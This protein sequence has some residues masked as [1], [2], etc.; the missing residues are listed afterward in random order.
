LL[1]ITNLL[2]A[3]A[4]GSPQASRQLFERVYGDLKRI[5]RKRLQAS[6]RAG[7]LDT[8]ALVHE[9]FLRVNPLAEVPIEDRRAFFGYVARAMRSVIIDSVREQRALKRGGGARNI[10]LTTGVYEESLDSEQLLALEAAL[11]NLERL[12]P[13]LHR[14]VEL[15]YFTGLSIAEIAELV[16]ASSRTVERNWT[17][18]RAMLRQLMSENRRT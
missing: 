7:G 9:A 13:E 17:K 18:A 14:I 10:T 1:E 12:A 6:D 11:D 2:R 5:A 3:S 4:L 16:G 15:R 8:T